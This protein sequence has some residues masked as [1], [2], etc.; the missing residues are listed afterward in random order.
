MLK[1]ISQT[2]EYTTNEMSVSSLPWMDDDRFTVF[3]SH[4]GSRIVLNLTKDESSGK[5]KKTKDQI[6]KVE[7]QVESSE[8]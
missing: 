7:I 3:E 1:G 2:Y 4:N 6:Y 5:T 8:N